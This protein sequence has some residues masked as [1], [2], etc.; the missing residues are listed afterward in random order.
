MEQPS[1]ASMTVFGFSPHFEIIC[2]SERAG[3]NTEQVA[4]FM[5]TVLSSLGSTIGVIRLR[6][7]RI[8]PCGS[9]G[10]CNVRTHTCN[11]D[12]DMPAI[13]DRLRAADGIVYAVPVHGYGMAHPMQVFIERAGVG[14]LR[15][16]RP[17]ANKVAGAVVTG[18]RYAHEAVFNQLINNILLNRMI[19]AGSGYPATVRG[20]TPGAALQ[21]GEGLESV[22]SLAARMVGLSRLLKS[23]SAEAFARFMQA[24]TPNERATIP[25]RSNHQ[26][27]P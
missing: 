20:G 26:A 6:E 14:Y 22:R 10:E 24:D 23:V 9:C 27:T 21:D 12:D 17:L 5:A 13:I 11:V 19:V 3:G 8:H 7:H 4:G 15:F 18:R 16:E 2:G 25:I 1:D